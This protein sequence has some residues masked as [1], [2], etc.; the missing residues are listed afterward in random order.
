MRLARPGKLKEPIEFLKVEKYKTD[1]G[2]WKTRDVVVHSC[3]ARFIT[4]FLKESASNIGTVLEN[5][6]TLVIRYKQPIQITNDMRLRH[7]G[8]MYEILN[9]NPDKQKKDYTT[10]IIKDVT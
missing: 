4:Q 3:R 7:N 6:I 5:T 2:E 1:Y 10:I 9:I 8:V